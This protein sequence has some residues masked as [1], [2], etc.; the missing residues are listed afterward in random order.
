MSPIPLVRPDLQLAGG[1]HSPQVP[2]EVRLNTNESPF[3][4]PED[5]TRALSE[6]LRRAELHRYPDRGVSRLRQAL[7]ELH[8]VG[9]DQ[10]FCAN[11][12]NEVLQCLL[13]AYGGPGRRAVLFE[14]TYTLHAHISRLAGTE[15]VVGQRDA[16]FRIDPV[17]A[18]KL[19][20]EA[21]PSVTFVC[22]P[23]N[24]TGLTE[25]TDVLREMLRDAPG[26]VVVDE[27]YGQ[28]ASTSSLDLAGC[29]RSLVV[30][31][32]FSKTWAMAAVR[33]GYAVADPEVIA[34]CEQVVLPYHLSV[35][36]QLAGTIALR[37]GDE[38]ASRV[39]LVAAERER[40][41]RGLARLPVDTWPSE[42]N[43]ILFRPRDVAART[44]WERLL[45]RSVLVRDCST[46]AGVEGCLRVTVG[47]PA[48]NDRFLTAIGEC[49]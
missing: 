24:P 35:P 11:G 46:W 44:V 37:F 27:A 28:F 5:F 1:Y 17:A 25:R 36:T 22:S 42:A 18:R 10:I 19:M 6:E 49:L 13:L 39:A 4:P 12:S 15:V 34:A 41:A 31:R 45:D 16:D 23:N 2:A 43:F 21:R 7:A 3:P 29:S 38:M 8:H 47:T 20:A 32:T 30:V 40:V 9:P 48:E 33:L 26:L 14:P